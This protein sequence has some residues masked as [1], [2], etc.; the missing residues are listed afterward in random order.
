MPNS[1]FL[2]ENESSNTESFLSYLK[3]LATVELFDSNFQDKKNPL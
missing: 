3:I 2:D 1:Y